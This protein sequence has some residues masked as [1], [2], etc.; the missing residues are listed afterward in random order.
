[1]VVKKY[2]LPC[3]ENIEQ[4]LVLI[5]LSEAMLRNSKRVVTDGSHTWIFFSD[6]DEFIRCFPK[7]LFRSLGVVMDHSNSLE[8]ELLEV[9][10]PGT[11]KYLGN[12]FV[13]SQRDFYKETI[14]FV[15]LEFTYDDLKQHNVANGGFDSNFSSNDNFNS[16]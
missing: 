1:M 7:V 14:P 13:T 4:F 8:L 16:T 12:L 5:H 3:Y 9:K 10:F 15:C 2:T 6:L 11:N